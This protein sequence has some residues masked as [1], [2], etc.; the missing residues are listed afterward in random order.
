MLFSTGPGA[1]YLDFV[2]RVPDAAALARVLGAAIEQVPGFVDLRF[3]HV[4]DGSPTEGLLRGAAELLDL[5]FYEE[6]SLGA[7]ALDL[8]RE[9]IELPGS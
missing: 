3:Y 1:D 8:T 5:A 7:P 9:E 2:G 6:E 4:I